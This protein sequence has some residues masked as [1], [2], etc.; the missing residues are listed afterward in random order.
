MVEVI[1]RYF[2]KLQVLTLSLVILLFILP[3]AEPSS[4]RLFTLFFF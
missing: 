4:F 2:L 3:I 1:Y